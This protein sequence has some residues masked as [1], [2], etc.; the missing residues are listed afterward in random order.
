MVV[1]VCEFGALA[2]IAC[3]HQH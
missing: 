1:G 3:G 2:Y